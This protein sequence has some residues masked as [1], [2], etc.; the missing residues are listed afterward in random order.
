MKQPKDLHQ[1][2]INNNNI[3]KMLNLTNNDIMNLVKS[4]SY[5]TNLPISKNKTSK[6]QDNSI[7]NLKIKKE[8][9]KTYNKLKE[10]ENS[11]CIGINAIKQ[12]RES[13]Q[14]YSYELIGTKNIVENNIINNN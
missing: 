12:K 5:L 2:E 13:L 1:N 10:K 4:Q 9:K 3:T 8:N 14:N 6:N 11:I 7:N